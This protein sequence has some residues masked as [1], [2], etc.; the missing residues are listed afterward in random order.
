[1]SGGDFECAIRSDGTLWCWG[2]V[3][4]PDFVTPSQIGT[5]NDWA[6]VAGGSLLL[7]KDGTMWTL[8][9]GGLP[10]QVGTA[11]N[12]TAI[13]NGYSA[14]CAIAT[15]GTLWCGTSATTL[16]IVDGSVWTEIA[17]ASNF[18][19]GIHADGSLWCWGSTDASGQLG[20]SASQVANINVP[21][22][23]GT[24]Q[25]TQVA[26][27]G[28]AACGIQSDGSL[29]CWGIGLGAS[30]PVSSPQQVGTGT[31]WTTVSVGTNDTACA[32]K[33]DGE[34]WCWGNNYGGVLG[35]GSS[36]TS[37]VTPVQVL[38]YPT[39]PCALGQVTCD[40][41]AYCID[42]VSGPPSCQC[43]P[44]YSGDGT[45]C[46]DECTIDSGGCP[47]DS[48][49]QH[50]HEG[51]TCICDTGYVS[52][53]SACVDGCT[54]DNGGC[55]DPNS[56]C[57][58]SPV[59]N[60]ISCPCNAGYEPGQYDGCVVDP[61]AE[62]AC[63][64]AAA[65]SCTSQSGIVT[66]CNCNAG[67]VNDPA[68]N[69]ACVDAC[70]LNYG[71]C[72]GYETC[73]HDPT[74][75]DSICVDPC[76]TNNGGCTGN[77]I[78]T[79]S[80]FD[81]SVVCACGLT[82]VVAGG[83]CLNACQ[84]D[85]G[86]CDPHAACSTRSSGV[87]CS[88]ESGYEEPYA[89]EDT[90][91]VLTYE[92]VNGN[93]LLFSTNSQTEA[94]ETWE[95]N[96]GGWVLDNPATSPPPRTG[97]LLATQ[98]NGTPVLFG[99][100]DTSGN[101][102]T[103]TWTWTGTTWVQQFPSASPSLR[104]GG[105][106]S[107][108]PDGNLLLLTGGFLYEWDGTDW[109]AG[110]GPGWPEVTAGS[111]TYDS[112]RHRLVLFGTNTEQQTL[113]WEYD[114][115]SSYTFSPEVQPAPSPQFT[116]DAALQR[117]VLFTGTN[118]S[119]PG[120]TWTWDGTQWTEL[121]PQ[122]SPDYGGIGGAM[123]YD[124]QREVLLSFA[125]SPSY[126]PLIFDGRTWNESNAGPATCV[127]LCTIDNGNCE[128]NSTCGHAADGS[129]QCNCNPGYAP[130]YNTCQDACWVDD[131]NCPNDSTCSH[132]SDYSIVCTCDTGWVMQGNSCV[133]ACHV[134]NGG[135]DPN[136]TC[137]HSST[138]D[139]VQCTCNSGYEGPGQVCYVDPC[140]I[141][142][143]GCGDDST[144]TSS[145]GVATCT[146]DTGFTL[147]NAA[148]VDACTVNNGGCDTNA[149]C[150]HSTS[151]DSVVCTCDVFGYVGSGITCEQA[152][153]LTPG[154]ASSTPPTESQTADN[155]ELGDL[156]Q[157]S[158][159]GVIVGLAYYRTA[160][161]DGVSTTGRLWDTAS[162]E[163]PMASV[164]YTNPAE[165]WNQA[166]F[167]Q[168]I[169]LTVGH[170]YLTSYSSLNGYYSSVPGAFTSAVT[171]GPILF[172]ADSPD[173]P[174]GA[175]ASPAGTFPNVSSGDAASYSADIVFEPDDACLVSDH[176]C[177][178]ATTCI[179]YN[180]F[181]VRCGACPAGDDGSGSSGCFGPITNLT[182]VPG[183]N[184]VTLSW[185]PPIDTPWGYDVDLY[186][187]TILGE[188][189]TYL[190][191]QAEI[192]LQVPDGTSTEVSIQPIVRYY[193]GGPVT[194]L[195]VTAG[196]PTAPTSMAVAP[197]YQELDVSWAAPATD[198]GNT[199]TGYT[200]TAEPGDISV[201]TSNLSATL[202]G[203]TAGVSYTVSVYATNSTGNGP[204]ATVSGVK[205]L[206]VPGPPTGVTATAGAGE[207]GVSWTAPVDDSGLS[208]S[209][210]IVT[211]SSGATAT[212]AATNLLFAGLTNG[213]TYSFTVAATNANG[214]GPSSSASNAV[215]PSNTPASAT[216]TF[217][218]TPSS[219][220]ADRLSR[221][222]ATLELE[223]AFGA[224]IVGQAVVV[225]SADPLTL[226]SPTHGTTDGNGR[227]VTYATSTTPGT[228]S[229]RA[230]A[231]GGALRTTATFTSIACSGNLG[232]PSVPQAVAHVEPFGVVSAD[233]NHD[234]KPDLVTT[235][236][237]SNDVSVLLGQGNGEFASAVNYP[238][239]GEP[240]GV[241]SADFNGDGTPDFVVANNSTSD[242]SI[243]LGE[244]N[245]TL[246][247]ATNITV[248]DYPRG[249]AT[250]DFNGDGKP[251]IVV[252]VTGSA[253]LSVLLGRGNGTFESATDYEVG[254]PWCVVV[255]DF[256]GDGKQDL[257]SGGLN[258]ASNVAFLAGNGDGTFQ[259]E[260]I[261]ASNVYPVSI[262]VGDFNKDGKLDIVVPVKTGAG[263]SI[264]LGA[265]NGT[266]EVAA[267]YTV[268]SAT[269]G[270][271]DLNGDGKMDVVTTGSPPGTQVLLGNGDGTLQAPLS[272]SIGYNAESLAFAD[273]NGDGH[274]DVAVSRTEG[275][276]DSVLL[277]TG[278]GGFLT[279]LSITESTNSPTAVATADFNG[280]NHLDFAEVDFGSQTVNI[281]V[282]TGQGTFNSGQ[283]LG[284]S[285]N[286]S[287]I[288]AADVNGD[289][290]PDLVIAEA[291]GY[292]DFQGV[293]AT[294]LGKGDGTFASELD[295]YA[296]AYPL[297]LAV[298]DLNGDGMPDIV[299]ANAYSD[300]ITVLLAS[301][302]GQFSSVAN[303][304]GGSYPISVAVGDFNGD[305]AP[306]VAVADGY[307][308]VMVL[309]NS[310]NG[311]LE[312]GVNYATGADSTPFSV[313]TADV[314]GDGILDLVEGDSLPAGVFLG[315]GDGTFQPIVRTAASD[316]VAFG[317]LNGDGIIDLIGICGGACVAFGR[318]DGTFEGSIQYDLGGNSTGGTGDFN[319]DGR[320]DIA[321]P[322]GVA[323]NTCL[324]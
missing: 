12:W 278:T 111:M 284:L 320:L 7:K 63:G 59:D 57:T 180:G 85:N 170:T 25:W 13:S 165:G 88:C 210:Y 233:I 214:T 159:S 109:S 69:G 155:V 266:F 227:F 93:T 53:S 254:S 97:A 305:W 202:S 101:T 144:C 89:G 17:A 18:Q 279:A 298:S 119:T 99:G 273:F 193:Y 8:A 250:G 230:T 67:Y 42:S 5:D 125:G 309:L 106:M 79:H 301:G 6:A 46:T 323:L 314:N 154:L 270:A 306:D 20:Y 317:D 299:V 74:T 115:T 91:G 107:V 300:D 103:D 238:A 174:N 252:A 308:A 321:T 28:N 255:G 242:I 121:S 4:Y 231:A 274:L 41:H 90:A 177:D 117:A 319:G 65:G 215:T 226:L 265:G 124:G 213:V 133:D 129:L 187:V 37:S 135:C 199:V 297:S 176:L 287:A 245:G 264:L 236:E 291:D 104:A 58:H 169:R 166:Y 40:P 34:L 310:G 127:D 162:P 261:A 26:A 24:A 244:S 15:G 128:A 44:G 156:F 195:T 285:E 36:T 200:I 294:L 141:S 324:P 276:A 203:L 71:G 62:G 164:T 152:G 110:L 105:M 239:D 1:V 240:F 286:P 64:T 282:G 205:T 150:S 295:W 271:A 316:V 290:V 292:N 235:N 313:A 182:E 168:P 38:D 163:A 94:A 3:Q 219:A 61:C 212:T 218:T 116:Y 39:D 322:F 19:C 197:G 221:V 277:G 249:V 82:E 151:D 186:I 81:G 188:S 178:P 225:S 224:A 296:D 10:T 16:S 192:V 167:P 131:G 45:T 126:A 66:A 70:T 87:S 183:D 137:S 132:A 29:W 208:I 201:T 272:Y 304:G 49:C 145:H 92:P 267:T 123:V 102:L 30:S 251:D 246:G 181:A 118:W 220:T 50:D 217:I 248:G 173:A 198:N 23:V 209:S 21:N 27:A 311:T 130:Y 161:M 75:N 153:L 257:L 318:G 184:G 207:A 47:A 98:V 158:T 281:F 146:C 263:I 147:Q 190:Y 77:Q 237:N 134:D 204:P 56:T 280:D 216:S 194:Y 211:A 114:G 148:C 140:Q 185:S 96:G 232:L 303:Y 293:V 175:N 112:Y 72:T 43:M 78:C 262:A 22:Q 108:G 289:G 86:G 32:T 189:P 142:N 247:V 51:T 157:V 171:A 139:S 122:F 172:P 179:S 9:L 68:L 259:T 136:A 138:D 222:T 76:A 228:K 95:W 283:S 73:Q 258:S 48:Y 54:V 191:G 302:D 206:A 229:L 275:N 14:I 31:A 120:T 160:D 2:Y 113:L 268:G 55:F 307:G 84:V 52:Q 315:N 80:A 11:S 256:N 33:T 260:T 60:S 149:A 241:A 288:V 253:E 143:G 223:D 312:A 269:V 83:T 234:G 196:V 35:N 100:V 243:F